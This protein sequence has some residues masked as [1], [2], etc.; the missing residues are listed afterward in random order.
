M[1]HVL[2]GKMTE[3]PEGGAVLDDLKQSATPER[4]ETFQ[5]FLDRS[6]YHAE[7][8]QAAT[9]FAEITSQKTTEM[10]AASSRGEV[11]IEATM[12]LASSADKAHRPAV[13]VQ[14]MTRTE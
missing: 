1:L 7:E 3:A 2:G 10:T 11:C 12:R 13:A 6:P 14:A 4:D 8:K 9:G 5:A